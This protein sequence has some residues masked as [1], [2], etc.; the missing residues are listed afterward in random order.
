MVAW[1]TDSLDFPSEGES[2][3]ATIVRWTGDKGRFGVFAGLSPQEGIVC[4]AV[5]DVRIGFRALIE[6]SG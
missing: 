3:L 1:R 6:F 4:S 5:A 2:A